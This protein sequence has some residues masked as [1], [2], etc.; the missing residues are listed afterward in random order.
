MIQIK[1]FVFNALQVNTYLLWDETME[2]VIIDAACYTAEEQKQLK[3]FIAIHEL[4]P[5]KII[6]TH[7]HVDHILGNA[8]LKKEYG[9]PLYTHKEGNLFI[10]TAQ[11]SAA[12]FGLQLKETVFPDHYIDENATISFGNSSLQVLFT[13]GHADGSICLYAPDEKKL[14]AGD[15]LFRGGIGRTDLPTGDYDKLNKNI[16]EKLFPLD[17]EVIVFPGHGPETTIGEEILNNPF[18]NLS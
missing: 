10:R 7:S 11:S 15:V 13:P 5:V 6:S 1:R 3:D 2:C 16:T 18:I 14:F 9:I 4:H 8:F 17:D 12:V